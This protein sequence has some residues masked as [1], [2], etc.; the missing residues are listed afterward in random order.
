MADLIGRRQVLPQ[1]DLANYSYD[2]SN[3]FFDCGQ[4]RRLKPINRLPCAQIFDN[5]QQVQ[6]TFY[7][8]VQFDELALFVI[9]LFFKFIK[10]KKKK[11][12]KLETFGMQ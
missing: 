7:S 10:K 11:N 12:L 3:F 2:P 4:W 8:E 6:R 5:N 9:V 1:P